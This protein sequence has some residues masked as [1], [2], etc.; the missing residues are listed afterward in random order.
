MHPYVCIQVS[1]W[2]LAC[3]RMQLIVNCMHMCRYVPVNAFVSL[4]TYL[5]YVRLYERANTVS[6]TFRRWR[7]ETLRARRAPLHNSALPPFDALATA[8]KRRL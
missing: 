5:P 7:N 4:S 1:L 8:L 3:V 6:D 2:A